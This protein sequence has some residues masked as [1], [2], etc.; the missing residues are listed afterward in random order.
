MKGLRS[1][2][3]CRNIII[4]KKSMHVNSLGLCMWF[5]SECKMPTHLL[6]QCRIL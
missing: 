4:D 3:W 6:A 2:S 1:W 5:V